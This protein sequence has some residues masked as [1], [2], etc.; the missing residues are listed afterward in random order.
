MDTSDRK[1]IGR[2]GDRVSAIGLGTYGISEYAEAMRAAERALELGV[3]NVDTAQVYDSGRAERFV[4]ELIKRVGKDRVFVTTKIWPNRL[5]SREEVLRA[6]RE[7]LNRLGLSTV[8]LILI[9]WPN[10]DMRIADQ[11]RNFES[12]YL[13]GLTRYIGVSNFTVEDLREGMEAL[14]K[15]EIVVDQVRYS[16]LRK[17]PER[18]LLD[19]ALRNGITLQAYTPIEKGGVS[20]NPVISEVSKKYGKTPVQVALNYLICRPRVIPIPKAERVKH[21]E[22][23]AGAMGW[24]LREEDLSKLEG[25]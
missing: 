3:D 21:V 8:D 17:E 20:G 5:T 10:R 12:L 22:E 14:R 7:S 1:E 4:G 16:V 19:F 23:V 24:R 9:H 18:E 2:R 25:I 13:E 6:G 11:V 15:A